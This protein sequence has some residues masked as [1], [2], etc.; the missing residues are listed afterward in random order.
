ML[1]G[2]VVQDRGHLP[3]DQGRHLDLPP[4]EAGQ[5]PGVVQGQA[6]HRGQDHAVDLLQVRGLDHL[7]VRDQGR[8]AQQGQ[9]VRHRNP[10]ETVLEMK[11]RSQMGIKFGKKYS[12][13]FQEKHWVDLNVKY[14]TKCLVILESKL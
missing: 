9:V 7:G 1:L 10:E 13:I 3:Q 8:P 11:S 4:I 6:V 12:V 5:G 14:T 2:E